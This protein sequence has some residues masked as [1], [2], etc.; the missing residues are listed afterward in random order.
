MK[1]GRKSKLTP[2]QSAHARKLLDDGPQREDVADL[3]N[4]NRT[5]LYWV[6]YATV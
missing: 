3:F 1:F 4:V 2:Q 5:T 6:L